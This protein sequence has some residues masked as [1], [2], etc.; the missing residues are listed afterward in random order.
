MLWSTLFQVVPLWNRSTHLLGRF[1]YQLQRLLDLLQD[2]LIPETLSSLARARPTET[3][4]PN[5]VRRS[6]S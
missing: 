3:T 2:S 4:I 1:G 6:D 5:P